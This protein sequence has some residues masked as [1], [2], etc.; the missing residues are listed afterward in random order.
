MAQKTPHRSTWYQAWRFK[1]KLVPSDDG[2][3][4]DLKI[5]GPVGPPQRTRV[6]AQEDLGTRKDNARYAYR[7]LRIWPFKSN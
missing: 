5:D 4:Y 2:P 6:F 3:E 7:V 1:K